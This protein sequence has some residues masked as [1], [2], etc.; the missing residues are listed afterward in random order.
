MMLEDV[1]V[2][3]IS[4]K[5]PGTSSKRKSERMAF[6][7]DHVVVSNDCEGYE[8]DWPI[9]EVPEEYRSWYMERVKNSDSAWYAPMNR[10]YALKYAREHGYRY[11]V[12]IDDNIE[13]IGVL[14]QVKDF[15]GLVRRYDNQMR[16]GNANGLENSMVSFM[17]TVAECTDAGIV[18]M[19]VGGS[20]SPSHTFLSENYCYS[21]FLVDVDRVPDTWHGDFE[22]DIEFRLRMADMG[23][24]MVKVCPFYYGKTAQRASNDTTGCRK[25]YVQAGAHRGDNMRRLHG[26]VYSSGM[27]DQGN[28]AGRKRDGEKRFK[29]RLKPFKVGV[30]VRDR[31][32]IDDEF[33]S[34]LNR[35]AKAPK[36][37]VSVRET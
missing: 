24:P 19:N 13:W 36:E 29:H 8:T 20:A 34:I 22:D 25:A 7:C 9:V 10:S 15:D 27:S 3:E 6:A 2:C 32:R 23:V 1:I 4:G 12:Q 16:T 5:R 35:F 21:F 17:R 11:C 37:I 18:G 14:Y 31:D 33:A 28:K 30:M 26:D